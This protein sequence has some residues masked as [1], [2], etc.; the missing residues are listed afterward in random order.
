[1]RTD[2]AVPPIP[3]P[4]DEWFRYAAGVRARRIRRPCSEV[5]LMCDHSF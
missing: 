1:M 5:L 3:R 4:C 2:G